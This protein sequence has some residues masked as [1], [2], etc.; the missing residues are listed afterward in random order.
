L[1]PESAGPLVVRLVDSSVVVK[2]ALQETGRD[3]SLALLEAWELRRIRLVAPRV[4]REEVASALFK[5]CRRKQL[6]Q[7]QAERAFR[8]IEQ[9]MP[10]L[11]HDASLVREAL[12]LSLRHHLSLWDCLYLALAIRY[13]SDL[14]TADQ[15]LHRAVR[16]HYPFVALLRV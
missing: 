9:R 2:W 8:F 6:A 10:L 16:P 12:A 5:R 11:V 14:V 7:A 15:R 13:R 1:I 3:H 4:L